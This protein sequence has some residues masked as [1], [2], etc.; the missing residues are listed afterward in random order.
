MIFTNPPYTEWQNDSRK[1]ITT[2][3]LLHMNSGLEWE[4]NYSTICD[5]TTF[6]SE[7]MS[8]AQ[9]VKPAAFKPDTHWNYSSGTTN[10]LSV[11]YINNSNASRIFRF[12]VFGLIDKIGMNSMVHRNRYGR[13]LCGS[14]YGWATTRDW[15]KFGLL[16][17]HKGN[18]NGGRFWTRAG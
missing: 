11:F 12:L 3:D 2:N 10:L 17:L 14:S 16:Y 18:W 6:M 4:E 7:D 15:S 1:M 9:L 13:E 8:R 5:A